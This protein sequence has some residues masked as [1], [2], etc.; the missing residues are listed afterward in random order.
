MRSRCNKHIAKALRRHAL[1]ERSKGLFAGP[2]HPYRTVN[3][4]VSA[5]QEQPD[6][7]IGSGNFS[8]LRAESCF[9][10]NSGVSR[11]NVAC[12][13]TNLFRGADETTL[14]SG[15]VTLKRPA[16]RDNS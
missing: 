16:P 1:E 9:E 6:S 7:G 8:S 13:A 12:Y 5:N 11:Q 4:E 14:Y 15:T 10:G 2:A 3:A